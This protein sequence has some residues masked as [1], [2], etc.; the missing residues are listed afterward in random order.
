MVFLLLEAVS[1]SED[2]VLVDQSSTTDMN[3][4]FTSPGTNLWGTT[5][6]L[7]Q[8][9]ACPSSRIH[10]NLLFYSKMQFPYVY[11]LDNF[12]LI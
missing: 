4:M 2:P 8:L 7:Y 12:T 3:V 10:S 1:S 6:D 5:A 11:I 9:Y